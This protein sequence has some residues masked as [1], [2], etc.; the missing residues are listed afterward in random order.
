MSRNDGKDFLASPETEQLLSNDTCGDTSATCV[1]LQRWSTDRSYVEGDVSSS[2][3]TSE[4]K[5]VLNHNVQISDN[6]DP[7]P[8]TVITLSSMTVNGNGDND[9]PPPYAATPPPYSAIALPNHTHWPYGLFSFGNAYSTDEATCRVQIPL[10][11]FQAS[12]TPATDFQSQGTCQHALLSM[13]MTMSERFFKLGCRRNSF[14]STSY[15]GIAE[16]T[17]D[18]KSRRYG[19]ILVAAAVIIFLMALSLMVRFVMERSWWRR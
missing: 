17:Y 14:V 15:N 4:G 16:K 13:P 3:S 12:L 10:T 1:R 11:P 7:S 18:K 19:V 8:V 9:D 6:T 2:E 5:S